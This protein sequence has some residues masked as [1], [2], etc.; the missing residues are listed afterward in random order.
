MENV[1]VMLSMYIHICLF[2]LSWNKILSSKQKTQEHKKETRQEY[3][4]KAIRFF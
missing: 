1:S 3:W 4:N 2:T